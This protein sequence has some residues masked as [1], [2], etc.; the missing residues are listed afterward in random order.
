MSG[1]SKFMTLRGLG[2]DRLGNV[3][4]S[5]ALTLVPLM[6]MISFGIDY[7]HGLYSKTQLATA[8]DAAALIA[9]TK[10]ETDLLAGQSTSTATTDGAA[11]AL[12][13]FKANAGGA[14]QMLQKDPKISVSRSGQTLSA[15]VT[16]SAT[17]STLVGSLLGQRNLSFTATSQSSL[18]MPAYL[19]WTPPKTSGQISVD[20]IHSVMSLRES[21]H[22]RSSAWTV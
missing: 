14:Y 12:S 16:Y 7:G 22:D 9:I 13:G 11:A 8:A 21:G 1:K 19:S 17:P 5:F 4:V 10:A 6:G 15:T 3:A 2:A 20:L 18:T